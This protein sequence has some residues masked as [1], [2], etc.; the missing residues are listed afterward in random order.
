MIKI[1]T[2]PSMPTI[3]NIKNIL[4]NNGIESVVKGDKRYSGIGEL[5]P[6]ECWIELWLIDESKK[7][8]AA[9]L[10]DKINNEKQE[11]EKWK[12]PKCGELLEPQFEICWNCGYEKK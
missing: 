9:K 4:E 7:E 2:S 8:E 10:I 5:P 11:G 1:F 3:Y 12:C 6:T